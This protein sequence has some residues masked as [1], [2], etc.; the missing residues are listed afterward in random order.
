MPINAKNKPG[1]PCCQCECDNGTLYPKFTRIKVVI[2]GLQAA[3]DWLIEV[4]VGTPGVIGRIR[5]S[6]TGA[7][8]LNGSYFF[9]IDHTEENCIYDDP[10]NP[11]QSPV[12][13]EFEIYN[14]WEVEET[15]L[16]D[17]SNPNASTTTGS[18]IMTVLI[19]VG[20]LQ[21]SY[22]LASIASSNSFG[23]LMA[24]CQAVAC[25][26]DFDPTQN[27]S[28]SPIPTNNL[29]NGPAT[30]SQYCSNGKIWLAPVKIAGV[31][32]GD[33]FACGDYEFEGASYIEAGTITVELLA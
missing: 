31:E 14:D 32:S 29:P 9:D 28:F 22:F 25:E 24:G 33:P 15:Y 26:N 2:S 16:T 7:D 18:E 17:C 12:N 27:G 8:D 30:S 11:T 23:G 4:D 6:V 3:Y 21:A 13:Q 10:E 19:G 20:K 1:C 5:G